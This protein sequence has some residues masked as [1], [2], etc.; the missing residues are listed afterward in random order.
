MKKIKLSGKYGKGKFAIVDIEDYEKAKHYRW[1]TNNKGYVIR[2]DS[3]P[4]KPLHYLIMGRPPTGKQIDHINH[5]PLD[6]RKINLRFCTP[7]ENRW[8]CNPLEGKIPYLG[9]S[10]HKN[11]KKWQVAIRG[12]GKSIYLGIYDNP[13]E[14]A[15]AYNKKALELYGE[16]ANINDV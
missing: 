7:A 16:F 12:N 1:R 2:G 3:S 6:N 13:I 9:V 8:N 5:N 10:Y 15:R 14:A 4:Y 11:R